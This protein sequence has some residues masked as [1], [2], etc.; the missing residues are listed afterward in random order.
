MNKLVSAVALLLT[1]AAGA[2]GWYVLRTPTGRASPEP[3]ASGSARPAAEAVPVD[4]LKLKPK[5]VALVATAV[6][7]L[8]ANESVQIAS[9]LSRRVVKVLAKDGAVVKKGELL[10]K[11]DDAD[12]V[13]QMSELSVRKKLA[14]DVEARQKKLRAE[15]LATEADYERARTDL[16][17]VEAQMVSLGVTISRTNIRAPFDGRLGLRAVSE[18]AMVSPQTT[19]VTVQ[20]DT[21]LKLDVAL[22]ERYA[23]YVRVGQKFGFR[24]DG[25]SGAREATVV[26]VEP[27][28]DQVTRSVRLRGV[29]DNSDGS[30]MPGGFVQVEFPLSREDGGLLVPAAAVVPSLGGHGV[31]REKDGKAELAPVEIGVR[32]ATEVQITKGLAAGDVVLV[33]NLLRLRPGAVIKLGKVEE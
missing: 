8:V 4:G 33:T 6:G 13:A 15:G 27:E 5:P 30:L 24:V 16:A 26:A 7:T 11:L 22:P 17:L 21:S 20:D 12:L 31:Y 23:P 32:T 14:L 2:G 1:V 3:A 28:V 9:E 18:G 10:F 19:L 25:R 29:L